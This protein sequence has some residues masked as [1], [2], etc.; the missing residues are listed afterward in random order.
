LFLT[1]ARIE[2]DFGWSGAARAAAPVVKYAGLSEEQMKVVRE[3]Q[4]EKDQEHTWQC[5]T[6]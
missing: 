1:R 3:L 6:P 2:A 4:K 5:E